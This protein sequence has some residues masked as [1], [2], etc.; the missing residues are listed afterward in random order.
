MKIKVLFLASNPASGG[1]SHL[2]L[3]EE[4]REISNRIRATEHRERIELVSWWA[5]RPTDL[6]LALNEHRP[7][8]VHFSGHGSQAEEIFL[9]DDDGTHKAV[10]KSALV[11]LFQTLKDNV[12]VVVLNACYSQPQ[13]EAISEI[14]DCAVGMKKAVGDI[15]AINFAAWFYGAI[16]FGRSIQEAFDQGKTALLLQGIP[17]HNTP[18]LLVR[19]GVDPR[20]ILLISLISESDRRTVERF[21]LYIEDRRAFCNP[22]N[23]MQGHDQLR[24]IDSVFQVREELT[25]TLSQLDHQSPAINP[26]RSMR[27]AC[28]RFLDKT[29]LAYC[30]LFQGAKADREDYDPYREVFVALGEL[31]TAFGIHLNELSTHYGV[32]LDGAF[33]DLM[34][35]GDTGFAGQIS[36]Q[37][38]KEAS[39]AKPDAAPDRGGS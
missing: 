34:P 10:S 17:E 13:A 28:R 6:L 24:V 5:V 26:M 4:I 37:T 12:R 32:E 27:A 33:G 14:I 22:Y 39:I 35:Q 15:A 1:T 29:Q 19:E 30:V 2:A 20:K 7:H 36:D 11:A 18:N 21:L 23:V 38:K 3:D 8:I 31:R 16:A 25:K 9:T